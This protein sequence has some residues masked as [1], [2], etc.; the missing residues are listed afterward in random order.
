M[1]VSVC[2]CVCHGAHVKG[3]GQFVTL[4]LSQFSPST[5]WAPRI[6]LRL[7]EFMASPLTCCTILLAV[8]ALHIEKILP[9]RYWV[10]SLS[11]GL[12]ISSSH[13]LEFILQF[14]TTSL[15][16][17]PLDSAS[18][19]P[20][21]RHSLLSSSPCATSSLQFCLT[22]FISS[23]RHLS[24]YLFIYFWDRFSLY[25]PGWPRTYYVDKAGLGL[26]EI[27]VPLPPKC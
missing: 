26:T 24:I 1:C 7:S 6:E 22:P 16:W 14:P 19:S 11:P 12:P 8:S 21:L 18:I 10:A 20:A 27:H 2:I 15:G 17:K 9:I 5:V 4:M 3:R 13:A 23:F 25:N